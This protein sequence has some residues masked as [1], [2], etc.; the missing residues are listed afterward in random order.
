MEFRIHSLMERECVRGK[1]ADVMIQTI[2]AM[3]AGLAMVGAVIVLGLSAVD[4]KSTRLNSS[5]AKTSRMPS[6]A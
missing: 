4:R 5:H 3:I 6:S 2:L 1:G